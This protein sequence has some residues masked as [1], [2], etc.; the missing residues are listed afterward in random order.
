MPFHLRCGFVKDEFIIEVGKGI[1]P[2][3]S[4]PPGVDKALTKPVSFLETAMRILLKIGTGK[5]LLAHRT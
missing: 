1:K 2:L 4:L 5:L 3:R